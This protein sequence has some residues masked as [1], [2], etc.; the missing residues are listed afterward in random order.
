MTIAYK[1]IRPALYDE[2]KNKHLSMSPD[3]KLQIG[4]LT[5]IVD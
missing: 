1:D 4:H 3:D 5:D 2:L